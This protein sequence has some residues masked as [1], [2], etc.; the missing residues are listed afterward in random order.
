MKK[1]KTAKEI[2]TEVIAKVD[3]E[4]VTPSVSNVAAPKKEEPTKTHY[5][6]CNVSLN[7]HKPC[8]CVAFI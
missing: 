3:E 2:V 4:L 7:N 8:N 6:L 5:Y 1:K